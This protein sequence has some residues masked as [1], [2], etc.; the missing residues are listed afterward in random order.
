MKGFKKLI[1]T[2]AILAASSS[3]LA[4]Q[5]MDDESLSSTTGQDG[6]TV[7][8]DTNITTNITWVD[9]NGTGT[10][11][12]TN[13]GA[14]VI[15]NVGISTT[16]LRIDIDAGGSAGTATGTGLLNIGIT[17]PNAIVVNLGATTIGVADAMNAT[18]GTLAARSA[19]GAVSNFITF[20]AGSSLTIAAAAA[21]TRLLNIELGSE[22]GNFMTLNGN[23][24]SIVLTGLNI[25]DAD[26][27]VGGAI[28]VGTLTLANIDLVNSTVNVNSGGLVINTGAGLGNVTVGME[29]LALGD[30]GA[31]PNSFIGDIYLTGLSLTNNTITVRGKQ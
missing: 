13:A 24:G 22:P 10:A 4:M 5:A 17:N 21:G 6:L 3:A 16:G 19:T 15:N 2:S 8:L 29:R 27:G 11:G 9:R 18:T 12:Y 20:N 14:V 25:I 7:I 30:D 28:S 23:M 26:G 31:G 1:L